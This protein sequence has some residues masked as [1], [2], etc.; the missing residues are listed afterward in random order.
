MKIYLFDP[1]P[2]IPLVPW[3]E[4]D[5]SGAYPAL[6]KG[7]TN[8]FASFE[9]TTL[10]EADAA[11]V[12]NNLRANTPEQEEQLRQYID[13]AQRAG[14]HIFLFS[15]GD[16]TDGLRYDPRAYVFRYS[17][18]TST[19][20]P[21][22]IVMLTMVEDYGKD[23]ISLREK[24]DT[25]TVSFCG[26]AGYRTPKQWLKYYLKVA[27]YRLAGVV[28]HSAL[29]HTIGVYWRRRLIAV[30]RRSTS[31]LTKFIIRGSFSAALRTVELDP[32]QARREFIDSIIESDFVLAPKGDGNYSNR[33]LETLSLGRIPVLLDTEMVLP[34]AD[35]ID[36]DRIM[37]RVAMGDVDKTP[38]LVRVW[39]DAHDAA[40]WEASQR[41][42]RE[43]F[44][45]RLR[46]DAFFSHFFATIFPVLPVDAREQKKP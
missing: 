30:C 45:T 14:K 5:A 10:R 40:M 32:V 39:Y 26:Q 12:P 21:Q 11:F 25:P 18:Y 41:R 19:I 46:F 7:V 29:A 22:D 34:F 24:T 23:G 36:Y 16:L 4:K 35:E 44:E 20:S 3:F 28:S 43:V 15:C 8:P 31:V 27:L 2:G 17:T 9:R 6:L 13:Q 37:V 38:E 33:F 42:A 1:L